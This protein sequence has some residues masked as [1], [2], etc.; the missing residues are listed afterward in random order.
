MRYIISKMLDSCNEGGDREKRLEEE[1]KDDFL[2]ISQNSKK[3]YVN[4]LPDITV[5][6]KTIFRGCEPKNVEKSI[7]LDEVSIVSKT[8]HL[9][10]G[11]GPSQHGSPCPRPTPRSPRPWAR[12]I[13]AEVTSPMGE[14]DPHRRHLAHGRGRPAPKPCILVLSSHIFHGT[15]SHTRRSKSKTH[16]Y[17]SCLRKSHK[18]HHAHHRPHNLKNCWEVVYH[19]KEPLPAK[20]IKKASGHYRYIYSFP[21]ANNSYIPV[22]TT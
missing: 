22:Q 6:E 8:D 4:E 12:T 18:G 3:A 11:R 19:L 7:S 17:R 21:A 20:R 5:G 13:R 9:A 16:L 10:L 2:L 15:I 1:D 14:N